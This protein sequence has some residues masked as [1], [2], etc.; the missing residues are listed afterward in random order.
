MANNR[1]RGEGLITLSD[2]KPRL[3]KFTTNSIIILQDVLNCTLEDLPMLMHV[4]G[5]AASLKVIRAFLFAGL[6]GHIAGDKSLTLEAVGELIDLDQ[7]DD[8]QRQ[9]ERVFAASL[10]TPGTPKKASKPQKKS[11]SRGAG[12]QRLTTASR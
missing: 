10:T 6:S 7:L 9:L 12:K 11:V 3:L 4:K 1:F 8:L 2:G 5:N